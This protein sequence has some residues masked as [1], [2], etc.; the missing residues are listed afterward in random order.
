MLQVLAVGASTFRRL[1]QSSCIQQGA[2]ITLCQ[3]ATDGAVLLCCSA[4]VSESSQ[5]NRNRAETYA[6]MYGAL[7]G[8]NKLGQRNTQKPRPGFGHRARMGQANLTKEHLLTHAHNH[9]TLKRPHHTPHPHR[10]HTQRRCSS[11]LGH[12]QQ[13]RNCGPLARAS[14]QACV[15]GQWCARRGPAGSQCGNLGRTQARSA[16]L[17]RLSSSPAALVPPCTRTRWPW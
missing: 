16:S 9:L 14:A 4:V 15:H 11:S 5:K 8:R 7:T 17:E 6:K 13:G 2:H 1:S 12:K 10:T 3:P